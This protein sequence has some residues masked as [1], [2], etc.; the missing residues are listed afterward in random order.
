MKKVVELLKNEELMPLQDEPI[1][2][3]WISVTTKDQDPMDHFSE[4]LSKFHLTPLSEE[5]EEDEED[6]EFDDDSG[7]PL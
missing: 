7:V 5:S 4:T 1:P 6:S 2:E 3:E